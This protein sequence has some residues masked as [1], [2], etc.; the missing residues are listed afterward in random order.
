MKKLLF[1]LYFLLPGIHLKSQ[2]ITVTC[3]TLVSS[4]SSGITARLCHTVIKVNL[5]ENALAIRKCDGSSVTF[6][7]IQEWYY[8]D[9][10]ALTL[11]VNMPGY[12]LM[13]WDE[14]TQAFYLLSTD[15]KMYPNSY[16]VATAVRR[17]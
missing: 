1:V 15:I 12:K 6:I 8:S 4:D 11:V 5:S 7:V 3:D 17:E 13:Q 16:Y 10:G 9:N 2:V 14:K